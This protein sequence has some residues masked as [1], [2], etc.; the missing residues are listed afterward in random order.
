MLL[1]AGGTATTGI[2]GETQG[3]SRLRGKF[4]EYTNEYMDYTVPVGVFYHPSYLLRQPAQKRSA[5][6]DLLKRR[7]KVLGLCIAIS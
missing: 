3:I 6:Q 5:W 2:L 7:E 1:L 4:Y